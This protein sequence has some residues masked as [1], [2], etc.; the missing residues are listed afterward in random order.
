MMSYASKEMV[1]KIACSQP[2]C[3]AQRHTTMLYGIPCIDM[4]EARHFSLYHKCRSLSIPLVTLRL[5]TNPF[6][7]IKQILTRKQLNQL[8]REGRRP[9][10]DLLLLIVPSLLQA[11][12]PPS[13]SRHS[14]T[15]HRGNN[16]SFSNHNNTEYELC[17]GR[18]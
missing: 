7:L 2:R 16:I 11:Y 18:Q 17:Q 1:A 5:L 9:F 8:Q 14:C 15:M 3:V 12:W 6:F 10:Q 13:A 4:V